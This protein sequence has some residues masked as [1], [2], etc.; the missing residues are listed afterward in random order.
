ME[1]LLLASQS[2]RRHELLALLGLPFEALSPNIVEAPRANEP[3][4][5]MAARLSLTKARAACRAA[6]RIQDA[7]DADRRRCRPQTVGGRRSDA[8][9]T[10]PPTSR[11]LRAIVACDTVVSLNGN[12][13]GKPRD[14]AEARTMLRQLRAR[15]H[16][17][18]S[19]FTILDIA[20]ERTLTEVA[21]TEVVMRAYSDAEIAAYVASGDPMDKAGA[22]AIQHPGFHPVAELRGCYAN[23][24]G[25]PLC[26]LARHL[27]ACGYWAGRT[28]GR[29]R[30][31]PQPSGT[32]GT[33]R[34][35]NVHGRTINVHGRTIN[36]RCV[37]ADID[38]DRLRSAA[39]GVR[40]PRDVPAACQAHTDRSCAVYASILN[41][42]WQ[43]TNDK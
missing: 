31:R 21:E 34:M 5:K 17:V 43:T 12:L 33:G 13:L 26:H 20:T 28:D 6:N 41:G 42:E 24:M 39:S 32:V 35:I 11:A 19:A 1:N 29:S 37:R 14:E 22:Y 18:Y 4:A 16:T 8:R 2:P 15:P 23:V 36:V 7:A 10:T 27:R 3:P 9:S 25:L 38:P 40:S 30:R